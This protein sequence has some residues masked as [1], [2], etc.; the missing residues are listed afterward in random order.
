MIE[1]STQAGFPT[2]RLTFEFVEIETIASLFSLGKATATK[3]VIEGW[4]AWRNFARSS[5]WAHASSRAST[6]CARPRRRQ[7]GPIGVRLGRRVNPAAAGGHTGRWLRRRQ[8]CLIMTAL[9][10]QDS[11]ME[12]HKHQKSKRSSG[13]I[14]P[15]KFCPVDTS[16]RPSLVI[17]A[18][19]VSKYHQL[20]MMTVFAGSQAWTVCSGN[21][22]RLMSLQGQISDHFIS[23]IF[24]CKPRIK[25]CS[26]THGGIS[27]FYV[28]YE[29][30][31]GSYDPDWVSAFDIS[32]AEPKDPMNPISTN[33][34]KEGDSRHF[35]PVVMPLHGWIRARVCTLA[36]RLMR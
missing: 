35:A 25:T 6:S 22:N 1:A 34:S 17:H 28:E 19:T 11:T 14:S 13:I 15:A 5:P 23:F 29:T 33:Q 8:R 9:N 16:I 30:H 27:A 7:Q 31:Q 12:D 26:Y 20:C 36:P 10:P 2:D 4:N 3:M 24:I 32:A 21:S 18:I